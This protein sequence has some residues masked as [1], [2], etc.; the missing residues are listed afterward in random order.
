MHSYEMCLVGYKC[1]QGDHVEYHSKVSNNI[2]FSPVR[3][4]S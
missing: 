2:I 3:N 1:P 4:K